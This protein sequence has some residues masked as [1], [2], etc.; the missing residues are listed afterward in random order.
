MPD[1]SPD[2]SS[3]AYISG[4][5]GGGIFV[6]GATGE[7]KRRLTDFGTAP[8]WSPDGRLIAF[9]GSDAPEKRGLWIADAATGATKRLLDGVVYFPVWSPTGARIAF[10]LDN[11]GSL[12]IKNAVV[13]IPSGGGDVVPILDT[14]AGRFPTLRWSSDWLWYTNSEAGAVQ[15]WRVHVDEA[16]GR[17]AG[18]PEPVTLTTSR[19]FGF[20]TTKD[21]RRMLFN[22][23]I[24]STAVVRYGFDAARARLTGTAKVILSGTR[25]FDLE[26][27]SPDGNWVVTRFDTDEARSIVMLIRA[28]TGETRPVVFEERRVKPIGWSS[29]SSRLYL[30]VGANRYEAVWSIRTDGSGRDLVVSAPDGGT[31]EGTGISSDG[32]TLYVHT[33]DREAP[34]TIDL[35]LPSDQRRPVTFPV[36]PD[37]SSFTIGSCRAESPDGRWLVG[38]SRQTVL[39]PTA[40]IYLY[41]VLARRYRLLSTLPSAAQV[42]WL[43]DSR[44]LL[45]VS[46]QKLSV[47]DTE[48]GATTMGASL[49]ANLRR[50]VIS[51]DGRSLFAE[52]FEPDGDIWMIDFKE[53]Q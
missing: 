12:P 21:G 13:T 4:C 24:E 32:Q 49:D 53:A 20:D 11:A 18:D 43:Q 40:P 27:A 2:G 48:T 52:R 6:M 16:T 19:V 37:G 8:A 17:R 34:A 47:L 50:C 5:E 42:M 35:S 26:S 29:D 38:T 22:S 39:R 23:T 51:A 45:I 36:L 30:A 44:R 14:P 33:G 15:V 9:S 25:V 10:S 1:F 28:S 31:I 46:G 3:I 7:S 41:D